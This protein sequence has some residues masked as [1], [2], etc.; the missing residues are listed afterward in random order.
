MGTGFRP[1]VEQGAAQGQQ[2]V[3]QESGSG[4]RAD[5]QLIY[6]ASVLW[7]PLGVQTTGGTLCPPQS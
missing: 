4:S 7:K 3:L 5:P 1:A 6:Q 2:P